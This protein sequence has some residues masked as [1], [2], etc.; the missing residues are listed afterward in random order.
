MIRGETHEKAA[1][2][3]GIQWIFVSKE[4]L[5]DISLITTAPNMTSLY[6]CASR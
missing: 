1:Q 4:N 5:Q 3:S 2:M 6:M